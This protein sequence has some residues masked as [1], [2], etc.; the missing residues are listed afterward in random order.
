MASLGGIATITLLLAVGTALVALPLR[1]RRERSMMETAAAQLR[2]LFSAIEEFRGQ[3]Y[4]L[5]ESLEELES[6]GWTASAA[7]VICGF[8]RIHDRRRFEDHI[9][10]VIRH[11]AS[12]SA[13]L[14]TYPAAPGSFDEVPASVACALADSPIAATEEANR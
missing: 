14:T 11:R 8:R 6:V 10:I 4:R 12:R 13:L 9:R 2:V 1:E 7:V 3:H 5:P